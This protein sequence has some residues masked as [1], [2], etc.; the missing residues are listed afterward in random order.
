[1]MF[2][3]SVPAAWT[4]SGALSSSGNRAALTCIVHT[5]WFTQAF[6]LTTTQVRVRGVKG[7]KEKIY[8]VT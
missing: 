2:R 1:M 5:F 7:K 8:T 4:L 3:V 6:L